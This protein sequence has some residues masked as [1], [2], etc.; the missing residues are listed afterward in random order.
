MNDLGWERTV[1]Y[2][3]EYETKLRAAH[4][5]CGGHSFRN[6]L[7]AYQY[8]PIDLAAVCD[9]DGDKAAAFA[10]QFGAGAAYTDYARMLAE[11]RPQAVFI[12]TNYEPDGRPQ[13]VDL[14]LAALAAGCHVWMEKPPASSVAQ[15]EALQAAARKHDRQV[16]VGF[17]KMFFP[18]VEKVKEIIGR[19]DEFG[20]VSSLYVRY[21]Q[22]I[23]PFAQRGDG[24]TMRN[25]LDHLVHPASILR[26]LM[27][28][29][30]S[31]CYYE[32]RTAGATVG[33]LQ[34][35]SGAVGT[36]H[37]AA[38]ISGFS[39]LERLEVI[40]TGANVVLDNGVKLTY[41][42]KGSRGQYG[43]AMA[44][45]GGD[46][47]APLYWEPEFS[48]G[49]LWNKNLFMLGYAQE[50]IY[51]CEAVLAGRPVEKANLD[52][53]LAIMR[54]YEAYRFNPPGVQVRF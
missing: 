4:I 12:V 16:L 11:V 36:L 39:P 47:T 15:I 22:G 40:G 18:G 9:L 24:Y 48:L 8:A 30:A 44:F 51:F 13:S 33:I 19:A 3:H 34:F 32:E 2:A 52:D 20:P 31:L 5:G 6:I 7:P 42:R 26:Y 38:G 27:G 14:A 46:E 21:P 23:P 1:K 43:R 53:A 17:K 50:I 35:Q 45:T 25:F 49:T 41:Y 10:R 29:L 54:L 28:D 37:L